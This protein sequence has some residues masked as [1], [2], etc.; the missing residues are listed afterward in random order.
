ME[1]NIVLAIKKNRLANL[2]ANGKNNT[3]VVRKLKREIRNLENN[4][5]INR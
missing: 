3:G 1:K 4:G 5:K 2:Q